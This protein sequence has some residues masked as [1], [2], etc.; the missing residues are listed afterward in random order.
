MGTDARRDQLPLARRHKTPPHR[1]LLRIGHHFFLCHILHACR[2][3]HGNECFDWTRCG[4]HNILPFGGATTCQ[5]N[6]TQ[7]LAH[8]CA[9]RG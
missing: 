6:E 3:V 7:A 4:I 2:A 5:Q 1:P 8:V 9:D